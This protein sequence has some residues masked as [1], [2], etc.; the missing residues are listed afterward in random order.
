MNNTQKVSV[1]LKNGKFRLMKG[2]KIEELNPKALLLCATAQCAGF[3]IMNL[4]GRDHIVPKR[5]EITLEGVVDTTRLLP[6]SKFRSFKISYNIESRN[7]LEQKATSE[8]V[9]AA[10]ERHC[11]MI[12][13]LRKIA[14]V[15]HEISIVSTETTTV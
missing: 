15:S 4:L 14:P 2:V 10:Q 11:G 1:E 6:E 5:C 9:N 13:M 8:A 3:T 12:A 7:M